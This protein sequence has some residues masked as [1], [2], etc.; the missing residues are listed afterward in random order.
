MSEINALVEKAIE[1]K[2]LHYPVNEAF[3]EIVEKYQDMVFGY[4]YAM[5]REYYLTEDITQEVFI[6]AYQKLETLINYYAFPY[7]IKQIARRECI[8]LS[9]QRMR[10]ELPLENVATIESGLATPQQRYEIVESQ[11]EIRDAIEALPEKQRIP[12]V[13]YYINGYSQQD[14]AQ[15][16]NIEVNTVKKRLQRGREHLRKGMTQIVKGNL[17]QIRP[18]RDS[19]LV[20]KISL[21]TTFDTVAKNGQLDLL[22]QMLVDGIDVNERDATGRTLLHWAIDNNHL[23]AAQLLINNGSDQRI[24]D[25]N[26]LSALELAERKHNQRILRL[27]TDSDKNKD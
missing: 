25:K 11:S 9:N 18:S 7:W 6:I 15:F 21:Y 2:S 5:T 16:L 26:G 19:K 22:E 20:D 17:E 8:R 14:V 12:V 3:T 1:Q 10:S 13:L 24:K 23:E 4:I 27:L